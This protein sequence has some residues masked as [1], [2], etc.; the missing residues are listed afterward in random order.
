MG[1]EANTEWPELGVFPCPMC[2]I[3]LH[4]LSRW[5]DV[6]NLHVNR[7]LCEVPKC[8]RRYETKQVGPNGRDRFFILSW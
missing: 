6:P 2:G 5:G 7:W 1:E 8:G 4:I 3:R